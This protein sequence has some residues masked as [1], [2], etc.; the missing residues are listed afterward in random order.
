MSN[1]RKS[2]KSSKGR[3]LVKKKTIINYKKIFLEFFTKKV[4]FKKNIIFIIIAITILFFL[5]KTY[6]L[7]NNNA[8]RNVPDNLWV[9]K[10]TPVYPIDPIDQVDPEVITPKET[11]ITEEIFSS[12]FSDL[13]SGTGWIDTNNTTMHQ[14][15]VS[16][17]FTFPP[18]FEWTQLSTIENQA[19]SNFQEL[20]EDQREVCIRGRC[21]TKLENNLLFQGIALPFPQ[22]IRQKNILNLSIGAINDM[23]LIGATIKNKEVNTEQYEGWVFS[24]DGLNFKKIFGGSRGNVFL[25]NHPGFFGFG[26]TRNNWLVAYGSYDGLLA[27]VYNSQ[28][29]NLSSLLTM[30]SMQDGFRPIIVTT[31]E[32]NEIYFYILSGTKT[33]PKL[34]KFFT[35]TTGEVIGVYDYDHSF[36]LRTVGPTAFALPINTSPYTLFFR[37]IDDTIWGFRDRG[38][39]KNIA[40]EIRSNN[41]NSYG[42][43]V[44]GA[45]IVIS[46]YSTI[47][48]E[49][50]FFL[51]N[52]GESWT[53][54]ILGEEVI[55]PDREGNKLF[56]KAVFKPDTNLQTSP[57]LNKVNINFRLVR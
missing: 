23:W 4:L 48:R 57:F 40:R 19:K 6:N 53:K 49:A 2:Q 7:Q 15:F 37:G 12:S 13:F 16:M 43:I 3:F 25:S 47:G 41:I 22:E 51:S 38:F 35:N 1:K 28:V 14:N 27:Q 21:L 50:S 31:Q 29:K 18:I 33:K 34:I 11:I 9:D 39:N 26:G 10:E 20:Q 45:T 56:W 5:I 42:A 17:A 32:E 36:N 46:N 8:L 44:R 24:F 30:R 52:N 55:F 54:A